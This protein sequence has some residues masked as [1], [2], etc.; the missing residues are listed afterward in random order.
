MVKNG[1][2]MKIFTSFFIIFILSLQNLLACTGI[3]VYRYNSAYFGNNEDYYKTNTYIEF[4]PAANGKLGRVYVGYMDIPGPQGG[5]ND[6]GLCFD[7]FATPY[8]QVVYSTHLP[9]LPYNIKEI[10][11]ETCSTVGEVITLFS[12]YNLTPMERGQLLVA[13]RFGDA[14]IIE[15]DSIISIAGD[16]LVCTNFYQSNPSLGG[17]PCWRYNTANAMLSQLDSVNY[18]D[19]KDI[20]YS[21]HQ[22]GWSATTYSNI[23]DMNSCNIYLYCRGYFQMQVELNLENELQ[24]G[25][26]KVMIQDYFIQ[27]GFAES[28]LVTNFYLKQN[29][30]N[31]FNP[32]TIIE[33][34]VLTPGYVSLIVYD[35][36]GREVEVLIDE[37]KQT[38][39]Y[40][41]EFDALGLTSGVYFYRLKTENFVEEKQMILLH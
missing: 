17:W 10:M 3:A 8:L 16:S 26:H 6:Q 24:N 33:Y 23:F 25:Y 9:M 39:K 31:P 1:D 38:G 40:Q 12:Q 18:T 29:Y 7:G 11:M 4:L 14:A 13:D 21:C 2:D 35:A 30:P 41:I 34:N 28:D 20:L 15:G 22:S 27:S 36:L 32:T 37:K 19:V 5:M